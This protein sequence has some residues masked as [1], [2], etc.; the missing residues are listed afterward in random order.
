MQR[1]I[2]RGSDGN[3]IC[4]LKFDE[5]PLVKFNEGQEMPKSAK[6]MIRGHVELM[7]ERTPY[8]IQRMMFWKSPRGEGFDDILSMDYMGSAEFEFGALPKSLKRICQL[9][10]LLSVELVVPEII[11]ERDNKALFLIGVPE[12]VEIYQKFMGKISDEGYSTLEF[13]GLGAEVKAEESFRNH[14]AWWDLRFDVMF[15]FGEENAK[16]V[17]SAIIATRDSKKKENKNGWF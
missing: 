14:D 7:R 8:L 5:E 13:V 15:A 4:R 17:M 2:S 12:Y 6:K 9:A 10:D 3:I 11:R 1:T 16:R